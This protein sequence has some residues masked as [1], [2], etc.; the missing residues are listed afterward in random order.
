MHKVKITKNI[1]AVNDG[2]IHPTKYEQGKDYEIGENL[3][4]K[5]IEMKLVACVDDDYSDDDIE[6]EDESKMDKPK[7]ENKMLKPKR[8][9]KNKNKK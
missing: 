6:E 3:Y 9:T 8:Q 4:K 1:D 7:Y 2:D 5:L